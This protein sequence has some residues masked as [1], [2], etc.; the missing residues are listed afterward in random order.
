MRFLPRCY[1]HSSMARQR[2]GQHFLKNTA[3]RHRILQRLPLN[4]GDT[5][6]EIGAGH[7]EM[8]ELLAP[9]VGRLLAV[10]TDERLLPSLQH[11]ANLEWPNVQIVAGDV[12]TLD[13]TSLLGAGRIRVYGNL[14]YYIT[15][16]IF[17]RLFDSAS[18]LSSIFVV[19]QLE[20]AERIV[21]RP[22]SRDYGYLST[23]CQF[24]G[25][26]SIE[27]RIPPGAF[28]PAPKV[29]SALVAMSLPGARVSLA[30][31]DDALFLQFL[32][33]CFA[34][35]RKTLRNNLRA[36]VSEDRIRQSFA[37]ANLPA[38]ARAEQISLPQFA[39]LFSMLS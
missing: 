31:R 4:A 21:A 17:R 25:H 2:L 20:V 28:E 14:P 22:G 10:E 18:H 5:W 38:D 16:P 6:L 19:I 11:R 33:R 3:W 29:D 37:S 13:L 36:L 27:L 32:Q 1:T 35:K 23:L 12:L 39:A 9:R 7:G 30:I 26:P 24:Y 8:T 15:S 34:Q